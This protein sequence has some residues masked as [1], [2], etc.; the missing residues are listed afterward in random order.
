MS[1]TILFI[2]FVF[3]PFLGPLPRH[4]E[5]S[6]ARGRIGA[7]AA[8]L[9][10]GHSNSGIRAVS[11]TYTTAH[12]NA[13]SLTHGARPGIEP[14]T[15]WLPVRF[16]NHCAT[17]GTP[18][19]TILDSTYKEIIQ[20]F[21]LYVWLFSFIIIPFRFSHIVSNVRISFYFKGK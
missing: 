1:L 21:P 20:C 18:S 12:G 8:S 6:Q 5:V 2:Y 3:L 10:Q 13:G 17:T 14:E 19:L 7:V 4:M 11:A 9:C 16:V 15:S